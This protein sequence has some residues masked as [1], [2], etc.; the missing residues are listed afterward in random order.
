MISSSLER[1]FVGLISSGATLVSPYLLLRDISRID[2]FGQPL[3][4]I[5]LRH[6]LRLA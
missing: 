4:D 3:N 1:R 6:T 5:S 2:L